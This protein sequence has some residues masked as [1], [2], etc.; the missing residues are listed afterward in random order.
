M[1]L[2]SVEEGRPQAPPSQSLLLRQVE[3]PVQG[4]APG[5]R[6]TLPAGNR[7]GDGAAPQLLLEGDGSW[8]QCSGPGL[9]LRQQIH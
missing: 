2:L 6:G 3:Q 9:A 5:L 4:R 8:V 7:H 1:G